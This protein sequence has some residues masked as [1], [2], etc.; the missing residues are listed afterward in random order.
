M[1]PPHIIT[2]HMLHAAAA[3]FNC[4]FPTCSSCPGVVGLLAILA[5][6]LLVL[7]HKRSRKQQQ[8][9]HTGSGKDCAPYAAGLLDAPR[10]GPDT[11]QFPPDA[12]EEGRRLVK[13]ADENISNRGLGMQQSA[14]QSTGDCA[15]SFGRNGVHLGKLLDEAIATAS[16]TNCCQACAVRSQ[17]NS[18]RL[19]SIVAARGHGCVVFDH[20]ASASCGVLL[21]SRRIIQHIYGALQACSWVLAVMARCMRPSGMVRMWR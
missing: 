15:A 4:S 8:Q 14:R 20:D 12:L 19:A 13:G 10:S 2:A 16:T 21:T 1:I 6:A 7:R 9:Q 17:F 18:W 11:S 5:T 3:C